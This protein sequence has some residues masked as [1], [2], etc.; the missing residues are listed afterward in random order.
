MIVIS[1]Q[2]KTI[3]LTICFALFTMAGILLASIFENHHEESVKAF[4]S[5]EGLIRENRKI[6]I[7][8]ITEGKVIA[9]YAPNSNIRNEAISFLDKVSGLYVKA[10]PIPEKGQIIRIPFD[11]AVKVKN[12]WITDSGITIANELYVL[13][14]DPGKPFLLILDERERPW[15]FN[16]DADTSK[17]LQSLKKMNTDH[18][19][20]GFVPQK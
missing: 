17:L 5:T 1:I 19:F 2:K 10:K 11:P 9:E 14:P 13:F 4:L 16:F 18:S 8:D 20:A 6:E 7:F 15:F 12:K 3:W